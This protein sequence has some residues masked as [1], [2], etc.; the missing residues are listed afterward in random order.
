MFLIILPHE[1]MTVGLRNSLLRFNT[2][3]T[4]L[5]T[6]ALFLNLF[7]W[8]ILFLSSLVT[9]LK[10]HSPIVQKADNAI[11]WINHYPLDS[12]IGLPNAYSWDSDLFGG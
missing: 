5:I 8:S 6:L 9:L 4:Y 1:V 3:R 10:V 11:H 2:W 7:L 12:A